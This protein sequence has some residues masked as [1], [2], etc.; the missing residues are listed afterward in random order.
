MKMKRNIIGLIILFVMIIFLNLAMFSAESY[1]IEKHFETGY[2]DTAGFDLWF[3]DNSDA[4]VRYQEV[5]LTPRT[6]SAEE[7]EIEESLILNLFTDKEWSSHIDRINVDVN[8]TV[9]IRGRLKGYNFAYFI[10]STYEG[11]SYVT[12]DIPEDGEYYIITS[13]PDTGIHYLMEMDRSRMDIVESHP[14]LVSPGGPGFENSL[15]K[16]IEQHDDPKSAQIDVM[17]VYTPNANTWA[18]NN[19]GGINNVIAQAMSKAQLVNDNSNTMLNMNLVHSAQVSYTESGN[20][21]TDLERL[22]ITNDGHMDIV[23]TWRNTYG[24]DLV[25]LFQNMSSPGG[26]AW[27][28][29]TTSGRPDLAFSITRVQQAA[30][31]YTHM[32]EMG[33]NMGT[34]HHKG[35]NYQ[36]GPGLYYFSAGWR[37]TGAGGGKY[38]TIMTYESGQ[39]F[40][41]GVTH[42]HVP[43]FSNPS[44]NYDGVATGHANDGDNARGLR[45][46]R[47]VVAGYR[48]APV[49]NAP[50][51]L[52]AL[53]ISSYQINLS[54]T[55]NSA[56]EEGFYIE[57][58]TGVGGTWSQIAAVGANVT[59]YD[60]TGL[61][62]STTY[63]YRV[64]AYNSSGNSGYSNEANATTQEPSD[65][66][67][68]YRFFNTVKG[69]H[70]YTTSDIER[71]YIIDNLPEWT[72][73]G[74]KFKVY[75]VQAAGS[76]AVYRFFNTITGI[77]LYTISEYERDT[78]M[79]LPEWNYED[80]KFFVHADHAANAIPIYRF[81][82]HVH[83]GHLYTI[84]EY[85][86]DAVMQLPEWTYE[87]VPFYV[88]PL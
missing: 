35:Q 71:D 68:V 20:A 13:M 51:N 42:Y 36:P 55:D 58:K 49:P 41:D 10:L 26:I 61:N 53:S 69:G 11:K 81:F 28:L 12:I 82:N 52:Q 48:S 8:G 79:Q 14:A 21:A 74:T 83:G 70:L 84:S 75:S 72:Y 38:C 66:V 80:V 9:A 23:H 18:N 45:N 4:V 37:W 73:E 31:S 76:T 39:Y 34:H 2:K 7:W 64:R 85:E 78:V 16:D 1:L 63:Y 40:P 5:L 87:G 60:N 43:H 33:H 77:H 32:H 56:N 62:A 25:A 19:A 57:R 88:L 15:I 50:S 3:F 27:L 59:S 22:T 47:N 30:T 29:N 6:A 46:I 17:I 86:R 67:P 65:E 44:I 54:W 24:A